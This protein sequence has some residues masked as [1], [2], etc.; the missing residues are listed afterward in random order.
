MIFSFCGPCKMCV[1][2]VEECTIILTECS[3]ICCRK[4]NSSVIMSAPI[5]RLGRLDLRSKQ[6]DM[7]ED[8]RRQALLFAHY[9]TDETARLQFMAETYRMR[10]EQGLIHTESF[11]EI[12]SDLEA[13][14]EEDLDEL[15]DDQEEDNE[16][17]DADE[18]EL[19]G[20]KQMR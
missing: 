2:G 12:S 10:M 8:H 7:E 4:K 9:S 16:M 1:A 14:L 20:I 6:S 15:D 11:D 13:A 18:A 17:D 19:L 5:R 3:I